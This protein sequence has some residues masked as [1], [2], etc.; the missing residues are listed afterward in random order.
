MATSKETQVAVKAETPLSLPQD[1]LAGLA[2]IAKDE[3]AKER[4]S[5]SKISLKS[6]VM[7]YGGAPMPGNKVE[8]VILTASYR[9]AYYAERFDPNNI[10]NPNCF[11]LAESDDDMAPHDNVAEPEHDTCD[12]C[13]KAEWG[14]DPNGGRG[15]ACKQTRRLVLMPATVIDEGA[16]KL[17]SA[18]LAVLDLPVTSVKNY[19]QF[20]N[21]LSA[22]AGVPVWAAVAQISVVPDAK[23]QFKVLFQAMRIVPSMDV[24]DA[25][26]LR[27]EE[28]V[29]IGLQ[30][31]DETAIK[32]GEVDQDAMVKSTSTPKKAAKF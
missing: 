1:V 26:K 6:G 20:V 23:T 19:S 30:P 29:R 16:E 9:N 17:K 27:K 21:T 28:A 13:P 14:S 12:G 25:I 22:S 5:L 24:L 18:E 31:Y 3:A 15:K 32:D 2:E 7:S 8:A 10:K 11:A 4:P